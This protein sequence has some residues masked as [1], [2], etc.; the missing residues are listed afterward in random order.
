MINAGIHDGDI[1]I[2]DKSL[3]PKDNFILIC[4]IDGEFTYPELV[5]LFD[6]KV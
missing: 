2:V 4:S 1:V 3:T 6:G 5:D